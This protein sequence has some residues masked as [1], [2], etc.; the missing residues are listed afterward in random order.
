[1]KKDKQRGFLLAE[2]L[3]VSTFVL[4]VLV[5]M[6][7]QIRSVMNGFDRSFSYNTVPGIYVSNEISKFMKNVNYD[8]LTTAVDN[9]GY[10]VL[11]SSPSSYYRDYLT[12]WN[13]MIKSANV[14]TII[15]SKADLSVL[16]NSLNSNF[17]DRF[18]E[19][20][21]TFSTDEITA[22]YRLFIEYNND[23]YSSIKIRN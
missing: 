9:N 20:I 23:T 12:I 8:V 22:G 10:V 19:Y 14:K 18:S 13:G 6:Y 4:G 1:M 7:I 11:T 5:F 16:V 17:S 3:I 15:L 2:S 21:K